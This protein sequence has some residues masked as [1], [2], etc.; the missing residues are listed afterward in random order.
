MCVSS[1]WPLLCLCNQKGVGKE[2]QFHLS[3]EVKRI[4]VFILVVGSVFRYA[5]MAFPFVG[6][7]VCNAHH[8]GYFFG[9]T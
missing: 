5:A 6:I 4:S 2:A 3:A 7:E 1:Y 8:G 9:H